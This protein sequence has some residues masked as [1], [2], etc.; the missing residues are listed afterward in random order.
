MFGSYLVTTM[1]IAIVSP[2]SSEQSKTLFKKRLLTR[3]IDGLGNM[4]MRTPEGAE[5]L[6]SP[7]SQYYKFSSLYGCKPKSWPS[8]LGLRFDIESGLHAQACGPKLGSGIK[9][10]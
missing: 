6:A 7:L 10:R 8:Y 3:L 4:F 1:S 5:V 2:N 9:P